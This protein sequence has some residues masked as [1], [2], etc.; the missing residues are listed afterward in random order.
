MQLDFSAGQ[1][2]VV[3]VLCRGG[4]FGPECRSARNYYGAKPIGCGKEWKAAISLVF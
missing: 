1:S 2:P 3:F 4:G